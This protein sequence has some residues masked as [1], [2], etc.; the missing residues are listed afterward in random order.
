MSKDGYRIYYGTQLRAEGEGKERKITGVAIS[1]NTP[2]EVLMETSRYRVREIIA[3]EAVTRSVLDS[4]T[5]LM[6]IEHNNERLLARSVNG[7]GSLQYEIK[8]DGVHFSFPVPNTADGDT[9]WE[10]V[11]LGN[12]T[13]CS[14]AFEINEP[15]RS[16]D[17][18]V[19][20]NVAD[21]IDEIILTVRHIDKIKDFTLTSLPAYKSTQVETQLRSLIDSMEDPEEGNNNNPAEEVRS[22]GTTDETVTNINNTEIMEEENVTTVNQG[23]Q[24]VENSRET[25]YRSLQRR[26]NIDT[27]IDPQAVPRRLRECFRDLQNAGVRA[28]IY[29]RAEGGTTTPTSTVNTTTDLA[30]SGLVPLTTGDILDPVR[31]EL[32][33]D[34]IGI[35]MPIGCRG[36]Y[37]WPVVEALKA[38]V[39]GEAVNVAGQKVNLSKVPVVT[40]RL[41]VV[42]EATRESLFNSDGKLESII[43]NQMPLAI[44]DLINSILI[45][46]V[47]VTADCNITGPF[48]GKT[49]TNVAATFKALNK[50]KA[51]LLAKGF[52]SRR[53]VWVMT[54]A[55]KAELEAT[56]KDT[57]SGIMVCENDK[58]AGLPV[59]CNEAIG[60]GNIGLGDF[61]YQVAGQFGDVY[62]VYDPYSEADANVVRFVLNVDFGTATLMK[63][64][65]GLYKVQ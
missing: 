30:N 21:G 16:V 8:P 40:Q 37:E 25:T 35:R 32:I 58:V 56:P 3:P 36:S 46:P 28:T 24:A 10:H 34:K 2:S 50:E 48:V 23:E 18:T 49:A 52:K 5:I 1:F 17:R 26:S 33:Y 44:A 20:K 64:A 61:T 42:V 47:M 43:R 51:K 4:G 6:T 59:F 15:R 60:E 62:L 9:A 45:S 19:Q 11:R 65:F 12:Y 53:M 39:A 38:T 22:S 41:A 14:F 29:L 55:M 27:V 63:D 13:G 54:E 57:G 31:E 7:E